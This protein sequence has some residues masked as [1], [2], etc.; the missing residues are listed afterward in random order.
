MH[1]LIIHVKQKNVINVYV[2][3]YFYFISKIF[4]ACYMSINTVIV[5][6]QQKQRLL[7]E[8]NCF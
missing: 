5:N 7:Y 6:S 2:F 4:N 3:V 1:F 8:F